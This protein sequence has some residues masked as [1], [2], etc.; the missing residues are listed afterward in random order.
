MEYPLAVR[1]TPAMRLRSS[2]FSARS[3]ARSKELCASTIGCSGPSSALS[4]PSFLKSSAIDTTF[5][6]KRGS[7]AGK[8]LYSAHGAVARA[9]YVIA[10][11]LCSFGRDLPRSGMHRDGGDIHSGGTSSECGAD[12]VDIQCFHPGVRDL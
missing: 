1:R 9:V 8:P 2:R 11:W 12:G 3:V 10:F 4:S 7:R 6:A 5:R